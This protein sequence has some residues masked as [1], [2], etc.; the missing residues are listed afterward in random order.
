M[1]KV[2][3]GYGT[4]SLTADLIATGCSAGEDDVVVPNGG[5][6]ITEAAF[7]Y[8]DPSGGDPVCF[9]AQRTYC[10]GF[11]WWVSPAV[12]NEIQSDSVSFDLGFSTE[13]CRHND[14]SGP[15]TTTSGGT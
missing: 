10:L 14:G 13:Q 2:R 15:T 7:S 12:E 6:V 9:P 1:C 4:N 3:L 5:D 11:E 8:C